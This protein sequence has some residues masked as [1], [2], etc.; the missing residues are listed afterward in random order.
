MKFLVSKK[1]TN[2]I[3]FLCFNQEIFEILIKHFKS[4]STS[5]SLKTLY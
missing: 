3:L 1:K 5:Q 4:P 2:L